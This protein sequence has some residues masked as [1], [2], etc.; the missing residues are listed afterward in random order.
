MME[1][2]SVADGRQWI[3]RAE[4]PFS[5]SGPAGA[6]GSRSDPFSTNPHA[7]HIAP[8]VKRTKTW[9]CALLTRCST[10]S[11]SMSFVAM[12]ISFQSVLTWLE[13][14]PS[15]SYMLRS[16]RFILP[17][18]SLVIASRNTSSDAQLDSS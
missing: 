10:G 7:S 5:L 8:T 1:G 14:Q 2:K 12:M 18:I 3:W 16:S 11:A 9:V 6:C 17:K 13:A 4:A 15:S